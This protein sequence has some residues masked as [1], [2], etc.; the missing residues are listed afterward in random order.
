MCPAG[1]DLAGVTASASAAAVLPRL[2]CCSVTGAPLLPR[3]LLPRLLLLL[4]HASGGTSAASPVTV[5]VAAAGAA[6]PDL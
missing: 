4:L 5:S 6:V 3:L 2:D 1:A